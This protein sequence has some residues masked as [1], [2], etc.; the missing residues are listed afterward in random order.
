MLLRRV[1][2]SPVVFLFFLLFFFLLLIIHTRGISYHDEG[3][4]L[5]A[6]SRVADGQIPYKDFYLTYTPGAVFT[7]ALLFQFF[8][9]SVLASRLL[10][11]MVSFLTLFV[12]YRLLKTRIKNQYLLMSFLLF[13]IAWAPLQI[14]FSWPTMYALCFGIT[15]AWIVQHIKKNMVLPMLA[16]GVMSGI[17]L[18][19]KQNFGLAVVVYACVV[20]WMSLQK[21][22]RSGMSYFVIGITIPLLLFFLYLFFTNSMYAFVDNQYNYFYK[23]LVVEGVDATPFIYPASLSVMVARTALYLLPFFV[24]IAAIG[25]RYIKRR[26]YAYL[27]LFSLLY[28]LFGIRPVTDFVHVAPLIALT[29][30]PM[31]D[32]LMF[33]DSRLKRSLFLLSFTLVLIAGMYFSLFRGYYRWESPLLQQNIFVPHDKILLYVDGKYATNIPLLTQTIAKYTK[34]DEHIFIYHYAPMVYF[35]S[36]RKN[37]TQFIYF[38][39]NVLDERFSKE[40]LDQL[41]HSKV[42]LIL[43]H[44]SWTTKDQSRISVYIQENYQ[45]EETKG[46]FMFWRK[47]VISQ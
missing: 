36:D 44:I 31:S 37:P 38:S 35:I 26:E 34:K 18:L 16:A 32:M 46:E 22:E 41:V 43:T 47:K 25:L 40:L 10:A 6:A 17:T 11:A 30:F 12:L 7:T 13:Y 1:R 39:S 14:N 23:K 27:S 28:Y 19:F 3:F 5:H 33:V 8:G 42:P 4:I 21:K 45:R 15:T 29:I 20:I 2:Q 9:E 24:A